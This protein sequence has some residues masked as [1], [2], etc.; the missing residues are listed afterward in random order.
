MIYANVIGTLAAVAMPRVAGRCWETP[1]RQRWAILLTAMAVIS[2]RRH[3]RRQRAALRRRLHPARPASASGCGGSLSIGARHHADVRYLSHHGA[4][5]DALAA[6]RG[7]RRAA[8]EGARRSRGAAP[9][10][11]GAARLDRIAGAAALPVQHAELDRG[12]GARRSRRRRAHDRAARGAAAIVAR[13]QATP[14]VPLDE[15]L[16]VVRAYLDIERV[17]FGDRLRY[18]SMSA[19]DAGHALVPR[20]AVQTLVENSVKYAVSPRRDGA[21]ISVRARAADGR[22]RVSVE[23]DGPG[24]DATAA[25][26]G[27]G[28]DLLAGRLAMRFGDRASLGV[29]SRRH[30]R[31][32]SMCRLFDAATRESWSAVAESPTTAIPDSRLR[33][34]R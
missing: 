15:E 18:R 25:P 12:A 19:T 32:T 30:R 17:R 4:G 27:H 14:L 5:V 34:R 26:A 3:V 23:D 2:D 16:R 13:Q 29:D 22:V 9:R 21:S 10:R 33:R 7:H 6:Q 20:L 31:S 8:H 11:R 28:L 1:T 24:F